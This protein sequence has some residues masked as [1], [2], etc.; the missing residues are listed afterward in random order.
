MAEACSVKSAIW[1][2]Y[3][4]A[5]SSVTC[6][7]IQAT[8]LI[9]GKGFPRNGWC[10]FGLFLI[11]NSTTQK[12]GRPSGETKKYHFEQQARKVATE[13]A[14]L[15]N[16]DPTPSPSHQTTMWLRRFFGVN[17]HVFWCSRA[18]QEDN[19]SLFLAVLVIPTPPPPQN[20]K[21]RHAHFSAPG[22]FSTPLVEENKK[23]VL[24]QTEIDSL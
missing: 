1:Q 21:V 9:G 17:T 12:W 22:A 18:T 4:W 13:N 14:T 11:C 5:R 10:L 3:A 20:K 6:S 8:T 2:R 19:Q 7:E 24:K 16:H 23:Q 15:P